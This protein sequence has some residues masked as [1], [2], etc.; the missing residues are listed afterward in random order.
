MD[1]VYILGKGSQAG[2]AEL[3]Y[4]VRSIDYFMY[5]LN[6]VYIVGEDAGFL[7]SATHIPCA[8]AHAEGWKNT[9]AKVRKACEDPRISETFLLLN[10]DFFMLGGFM[11]AE[12]PNFAIKGANG[13][14]CG[15]HAFQI[16][17]PI[18]IT[19]ALFL[20]MPF[21]LDQK[22]CRSWR[23]FYCN[24]YGMPPVFVDDVIVNYFPGRGTFDE[25]TEGKEFFSIADE[26]MLDE[27][28]TE[29]LQD[30]Y[31]DRSRFEL[32]NTPDLDRSR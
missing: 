18:Q 13:G 6:S 7:P 11:A 29:W 31:P 16:H 17:A 3:R 5:D 30:K 9:Y 27:Q 21:S 1:A 10:D 19:K 4:S 23:S 32:Q 20:K 12:W 22:A 2:N 14:T 26:M 8:D 15:A 28:F 25:Q 24:I